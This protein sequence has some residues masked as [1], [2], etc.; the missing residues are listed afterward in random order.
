MVAEATTDTAVDTAVDTDVIGAL[1]HA[2]AARRWYRLGWPGAWDITFTDTPVAGL[3]T[4]EL[5]NNIGDAYELDGPWQGHTKAL[6]QQVIDIVGDWVGAPPTRWGYVTGGASE[7][8]LHALREARQA[9]PDVYVYTSVAA[10][11]SVTKAAEI[12]GLRIVPIRTD[13][14]GR[15]DV[16][17]LSDEVRRRRDHPAV[18][19]ATAG[20]TQSEAVDDVATIVE[21]L[22]R[23]G[24]DRRRIHVDAAL[25]GIP[26]ALLPE[27]D[28]PPFAFAAGAT[29]IVISGHKFLSTL[30]P[31]AVLLYAHRPHSLDRLRIAYTGTADTTITGS[32]SGHLP[33]KLWWVLST[34]GIEG[35]RRRAQTS[36]QLAAHTHTRLLELGWEARRNPHAF[37]V[38]L[39]SPPQALMDRR[40]WSLSD[41]GTW[42]HI[43]TV[44]GTVQDQLD[45]FCDDLAHV[46]HRKAPR[47]RPALSAVGADP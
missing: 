26:L 9:Y 21:V 24:V 10:H 14:T 30:E 4:G 29:S 5:L 12:L 47:K 40:P 15:I 33:I 28:R 45:T 32:R 41:D 25:A 23:W 31:C 34:L 46:L 13:L 6:E 19:V 18:V 17:D 39:R 20:T 2:L 35:H 42:A 16:E 37:T 8:T 38:V 43:I 3:L 7:G 1:T 22:G 36:R 44:P 27:P 11:Y